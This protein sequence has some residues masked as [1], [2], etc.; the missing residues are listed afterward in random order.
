[1]VALVVALTANSI[2]VNSPL[3]KPMALVESLV[4]F[5]LPGMNDMLAGSLSPEATLTVVWPWVI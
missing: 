4:S 5:D 3:L 2:S 1:L